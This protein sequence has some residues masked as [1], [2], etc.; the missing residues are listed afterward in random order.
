MSIEVAKQ[1]IQQ[2]QFE[3]ALDSQWESIDRGDAEA[4][5]DLAYL[6][7]DFGLYYFA[8]D[9]YLYLLDN[10]PDFAL[11][12]GSGAIKNFVWFREYDAAK[13]LLSKF[14]ALQGELGVYTETSAK[15]YFTLDRGADFL[16]DVISAIFNDIESVQQDFYSNLSLENFQT[17]LSM[18]EWLMNIAIDLSNKPNS[19]MGD[20]AI[21]IQVAG[22]MAVSRPLKTWVGDETDR[23]REYVKTCA[24]AIGLLS[25]LPEFA[26]RVNPIFQEACAAGKKAANKLIWLKYS[27]NQELNP[28]ESQ[29]IET[30]CWGL[31]HLGATHEGFAAFVLAGVTE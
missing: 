22:S 8:Q 17:K 7:E 5:L 9:Q 24:E 27:K 21:D 31:Q 2:G 16:V 28:E 30:I 3:Q 19:A 26:L 29:A 20:V 6:F 10:E 25:D 15:N 4:R 18:D 11:E 14:S 12:A 13:A 23:T 1:L